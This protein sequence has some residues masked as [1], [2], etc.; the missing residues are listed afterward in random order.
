VE[1]SD[2]AIAGA[3]NKLGDKVKLINSLFEAASLPS[4]YD[5]IVLTHVSRTP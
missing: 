3:K 4:K 2:K 1:A 5:N